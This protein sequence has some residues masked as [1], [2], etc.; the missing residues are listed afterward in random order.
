MIRTEKLDEH[1]FGYYWCETCQFYTG[2]REFHDQHKLIFLGN[3]P[4][5]HGQIY[6]MNIS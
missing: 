2:Q 6:S 5:C 3:C 4:L 1:W